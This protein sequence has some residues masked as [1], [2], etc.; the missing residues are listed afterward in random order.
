MNSEKLNQVLADYSRRK[1]IEDLKKKREEELTHTPAHYVDMASDCIATL[2]ILS[3]QEIQSF[4]P[5]KAAIE[6]WQAFVSQAD[7]ELV[8]IF[9]LAGNT[10]I[11]GIPTTP[12]KA[13]RSQQHIGQLIAVEGKII[14]LGEIEPTIITA[15][16]RCL[17]C[18]KLTESK[19]GRRP[20]QCENT[21]CGKKRLELDINASSFGDSQVVKVQ[22]LS[23][24]NKRQLTM[25]CVA[26]DEEFFWPTNLE[27]K[28]KITGIFQVE[29]DSGSR[30]PIAKFKKKIQIANIEKLEADIIFTEEDV[31]RFKA[32][33]EQPQFYE[34]I[35]SSIAPHIYGMDAAKESGM[36]A[37]AS[38][39]MRKPARMLWIGDP[40]VAKSELMEYFADLAPNGHY[41]TMANSRFTGLTT[42]SEQDKDTGK[43]M[44]T[45]GLLAHAHNGL[46]CIDELQVIREQDAKNL[47]DVIERGKI[48]Y[49]LAG[50]NHGE[51]DANCALLL[52]CNPHQGKI[53][54]FENIQETLKFLGG[55]A[56]MFISRMTLIYYFRDKVNE[57]RDRNIAKAILKNSGNNPLEAYEEDWKDSTNGAEYYGTKTLKKFF[58]YVSTIPVEAI[59]E[60]YHKELEEYYITNRQNVAASINKFIGARFLRDA[61]KIAQIIARIQGQSKPSKSDIDRAMV[62]LRSHMEETAFDPKTKEIDTNLINGNKSKDE[63]A[64]QD[65]KTKEEEFWNCFAKACL[66]EK[67][68][69]R[70]YCTQHDLNFWLM[71]ANKNDWNELTAETY[72]KTLRKQCKLYEK[73]GVGKFSRTPSSS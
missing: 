53:F 40:G 38:I 46:V 68:N 20:W 55:G 3:W 19:D 8:K 13:I 14:A 43:W 45:P 2:P 58:Q 67:G 54:E 52:A 6:D 60:E 25:S 9:R 70:G 5:T 47:N 34:K 56:P 50:G 32:D 63:I 1:Q 51:L 61:V 44:V 64:R 29:H 24:E 30:D 16:Y 7:Y 73:E 33:M 27:R 31:K 15:R 71:M 41:T 39:G 10:K 4:Q 72:V 59:P 17:D 18:N 35:L 42:T 12:M 21:Q 62:L 66:D 26:V 11:T 49:A 22:E 36:L 23:S 37:L 28:V 57:E 48:R 65:K 69:D